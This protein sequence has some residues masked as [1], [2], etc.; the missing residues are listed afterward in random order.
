M[1]EEELEEEE[2][3]RCIYCGSTDACKHL[4]LYYDV[5]FGT[6]EGGIVDPQELEDQVAIAFA[7]ALKE[8]KHPTWHSDWIDEAFEEITP[9]QAEELKAAEK[10]RL[11][12]PLGSGFLAELLEDAGGL[13]L[14]GEHFSQSG[15]RC[16]SAMWVYYDERPALF[17]K[18]AKAMLA[19]LLEAGLN[20]KPKRRRRKRRR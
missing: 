14:S 18:K 13:R 10:P 20:P 6:A 15:G 17:Y 19:N 4:L 7:K 12:I 5:T 16:T 9:E 8:G 3:V 2:S 11:P 1:S